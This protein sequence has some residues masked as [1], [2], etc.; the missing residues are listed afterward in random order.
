[1]IDD[2]ISRIAENDCSYIKD[3]GTCL[4]STDSRNMVIDG[5]QLFGSDCVWCPDGD[6]TPGSGNQCEPKV[7]LENKGIKNFEAC[8]H[9]K[10]GMLIMSLHLSLDL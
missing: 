7:F 1:M 6:C 9:G 5:V 4:T 3:R 10:I 8:I 2:C